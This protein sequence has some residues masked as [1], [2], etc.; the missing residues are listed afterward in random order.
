DVAATRAER[1]LDGVGDRVDPELQGLARIDVVLQFLMSHVSLSSCYWS[2]ASTSDSR[3]TS[4]SSP[5]TLI[6]VP[7]YLEY[8]TSSP[9][10]TSSG[11]R[12]PSSSSLPSPTART[13]PFWGFSLAVSGS[14]MPEDV[15][16]SSST[17]LTIN[18][19]PR[20]LSFI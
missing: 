13:L 6:S 3:R 10:A 11:I 14:T 19:S 18:R 2:L 12:L 7:P 9:S 15:F 20:G 16:S 4:S 1:H 8:R 17:A 5:S